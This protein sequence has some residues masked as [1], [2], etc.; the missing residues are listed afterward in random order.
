MRPS[1]TPEPLSLEQ[2]H[3]IQGEL[4]ARL[5]RPFD[6]EGLRAAFQASRAPYNLAP[7]E[8]RE[9]LE[10]HPPEA[11][12]RCLKLALVQSLVRFGR[13]RILERYPE[14]IQ[15]EYRIHLGLAAKELKRRPDSFYSLDRDILLKDLALLDERMLPGGAQ[16]FEVRRGVPRRIFAAGGVAQAASAATFFFPWAGALAPFFEMHTDPRRMEDFSPEGWRRFYQCVAAMLRHRPEIRG[17]FGGAWWNDPAVAAISPHLG[18]LRETPLAHGARTFR[19]RS[20]PDV[21]QN[22]LI[23]SAERQ[24][25]FDQGRYTPASFLLVWRRRDLLA[26][27]QGLVSSGEE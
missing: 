27:E 21:Q 19:Y 8:A 1:R 15:R 2:L 20:G 12:S 23:H 16:L 26:W 22:A 9:V 10:Q 4:E 7:E 24:T 3:E 13:E 18:Y 5:G 11:H 6:F 25:A 14:C 17:V